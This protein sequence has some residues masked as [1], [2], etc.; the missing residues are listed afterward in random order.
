M[1]IKWVKLLF[2]QEVLGFYFF[3]FFLPYFDFK[4]ITFLINNS[5][6][7]ITLEEFEELLYGRIWSSSNACPRIQNKDWNFFQKNAHW[8]FSIRDALEIEKATF[9][10]GDILNF[11]SQL[12]PK[13]KLISF[14]F[15]IWPKWGI[16]NT[17]KTSTN[18]MPEIF[19]H[20]NFRKTYS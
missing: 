10:E 16:Q 12:L 17:K 5:H 6:Q 19:T 20:P 4:W 3:T 8:K 11:S 14:F 1:T 18:T 15:F 2:E 13:E 9:K 7:P